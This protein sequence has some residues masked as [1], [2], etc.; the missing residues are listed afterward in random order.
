MVKNLDT[1]S[2]KDEQVID[3]DDNLVK[4][5]AHDELNRMTVTLCIIVIISYTLGYFQFTYLVPV[6][7]CTYAYWIWKVKTGRIHKWFY[8]EHEMREH[9]R[10]AF[11]NAETVEWFN[12]LLNRW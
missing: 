10:R 11:Q 9:R 5:L 12:F 4:K 6:V 2:T 7:L 1:D 3:V 8:S